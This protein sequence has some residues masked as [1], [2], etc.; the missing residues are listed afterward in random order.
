MTDLCSI[1]LNELT[2]KSEVILSCNHHFHIKCYT[3]MCVHKLSTSNYLEVDITIDCPLCRNRNDDL[4]K[5]LQDMNIKQQLK[6]NAYSYFAEMIECEVIHRNLPTIKTLVD[7]PYLFSGDHLNQIISKLLSQ[8][9]KKIR[10]LL[11]ELKTDIRDCDEVTPDITDNL[12]IRD[13]A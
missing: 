2:G 4:I 6:I 12:I 7:N 10:K 9:E 1:C 3:N 11:R 13:T 8:Q 5:D